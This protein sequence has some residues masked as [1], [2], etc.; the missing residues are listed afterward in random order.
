[1]LFPFYQK[2]GYRTCSH[3]GEF[4][5]EASQNAIAVR[6]IGADEYITLRRSFIPENGVLQ[7]NE[8]IAFLREQAVFYA[9][10]GFLLA[11]RKHKNTLLG[12]ELLGES[13]VA[14]DVLCTLGYK[15]GFFRTPGEDKPFAM[16]YSL[17]D[18]NIAPP[19][20]FGLAFD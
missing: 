11:A 4:R 10:D 13:S 16:Y 7:E 8:N 6:E 1:M 5:C 17:N 3:V 14:P 18:K 2:I 12:I 20:Y 9:G 15:K 19:S